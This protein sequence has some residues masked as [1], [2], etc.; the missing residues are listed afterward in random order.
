MT[1]CVVLLDRTVRVE[2]D[3]RR[4]PRL[5]ARRARHHD[6]LVGQLGRVLGRHD[7]V[8]A[9]R[10]HHDLLGRH[11]VDRREQ[12]VR[13]GVQRRPAVERL[14]AELSEQLRETVAADDGHRAAARR[15]LLAHGTRN[16]VDSAPVGCG[17]VGRA[18]RA[19][20]VG[21]VLSAGAVARV[22][23]GGAVDGGVG[24]V[25]VA[26]ALAREP[27]VAL[28]DLHAHV[29]HVQARDLTMLCEHG[30]R[31]LGFVGVQVDLQVFASPTTSTESPSASSGS[32]KRPGLRPSPVTAKF[33]QKR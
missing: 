3:R 9:V 30:G 16:G 2:R 10:Q 25:A 13:G 8:G 11:R 12:V 20:T 26:R 6:L 29:G 4:E 31:Q 21:R 24:A 7:H 15:R 1:A 14:H 32:M 28:V 27:R 33:V 5:L 19:R 17:A 23:R 18:A 22:R